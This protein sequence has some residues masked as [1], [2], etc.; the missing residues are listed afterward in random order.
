MRVA[1]RRRLPFEQIIP[2][3]VWNRQR[4]G[5]NH[6]ADVVEEAQMALRVG[7]QLA[8][9]AEIG[10]RDDRVAYMIALQGARV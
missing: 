10:V 1:C 8:D 5:C 7:A 2:V 3:E 6:H 9:D 4:R